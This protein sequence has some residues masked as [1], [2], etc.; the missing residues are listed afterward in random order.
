LTEAERYRAGRQQ[1]YDAEWLEPR[2]LEQLQ[3]LAA[4]SAL[5]VPRHV[6]GTSYLFAS[7]RAY[8]PQGLVP[9][10]FELEQLRQP[11]FAELKPRI[12][13][14]ALLSFIALLGEPEAGGELTVYDVSRGSAEAARVL[15][16]RSRASELLADMPSVSLR[17]AQGDLLVFN[18]GARFHEVRR[19]LGQRS[20]WT[21][22]GFC[23][24]RPGGGY[25]VF[26]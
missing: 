21:L 15:A 20:R 13:E 1:L 5:E 7:V 4:G 12:D 22:G 10:H 17:L 14:S 18:G 19:V 2:L 8:P 16:D 23:A 6:S 24:K 3:L 11:T 25:F 9:P 26:S